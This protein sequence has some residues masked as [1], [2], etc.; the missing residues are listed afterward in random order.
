MQSD[1]ETGKRYDLPHDIYDDGPTS[2]FQSRF[3]STEAIVKEQTVRRINDAYNEEQRRKREAWRAAI[4]VATVLISD[5]E[6][7]EVE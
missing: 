4:M 6:Q 3:P 2:Q 1:D 5:C 7:K